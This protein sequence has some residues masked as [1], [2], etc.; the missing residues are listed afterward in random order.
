MEA[1]GAGDAAWASAI[2]LDDRVYVI[3]PL[4]ADPRCR[5]MTASVFDPDVDPE[6][7]FVAKILEI[8]AQLHFPNRQPR[9]G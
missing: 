9:V 2:Q 6:A 3:S 7:A 8:I 4:I 1:P 5:G